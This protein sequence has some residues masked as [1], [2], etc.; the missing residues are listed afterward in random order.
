MLGAGSLASTVLNPDPAEHVVLLHGVWMRGF[1]LVPLARR[2]QAQGF[3]PH[4]FDYASLFSGPAPS[5]DRLAAFMDRL[6]P[7]PVHLVGHSLGGLVALETLSSYHGLPPGRVVCLGS[8][9]AGSGA[10]RGLARHHLS[11]LLGRSGTLLR[12]GLAEL[13]PGREVGVLAGSRA[14][15]LGKL[16]NDMDGPGDGTVSVWETRLPG[17]ADH[18]V[19][20]VSH[21]GLIL[22]RVAAAMAADFLRLGRFPG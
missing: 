5:V 3:V 10:A 2:L 18:R 14:A 15:G 19:L 1:S 20:P 13:P 6:G 8:P 4:R 21:T 12:S 16:F 7:G 22:S 11:A 17:L 9:L